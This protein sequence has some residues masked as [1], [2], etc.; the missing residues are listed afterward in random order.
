[1]KRIAISIAF[2]LFLAPFIAGNAVA[3]VDLDQTTDVK[4]GLLSPQTGELSA[5]TGGFERAAELAVD[6][7]NDDADFADYTFT[8]TVY[9]TQTSPTGA[10]AAMTQAVTDGMH[11]VVG[12][13]GSS[14]TLAAAAVAV[15]NEVPLISYASTS[16]DLTTF[17]DNGYLWRTPP[18]DALQGKVIADVADEGGYTE[19][20]IIALDNAYGAGL[21]ASV[22]SNFE[23]GDGT[24]LK[25]IS[26]AAETTDFANIVDQVEAESP[27]I[28]VAISY[29]TDGS[30]LFVEMDTQELD[31][32]VIGADGIADEQI[33]AATTGT[34]EAMEGFVTTKPTA[35]SSEAGTAFVAAYEAAYPDATGDIYT[36]ETY[37][38]VLAGAIAI[39]DAA[40]TAGAD[41]IASLA[42][43]TFDGATGPLQFDENGDSSAGFYEIGNVQD[44]AIVAVGSWEPVGGLDI[45]DDDFASSWGSSSGGGVLPFP[46]FGFFVAIAF[47]AVIVR[48]RK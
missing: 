7:L 33:F 37:D 39:K 4:V 40:S 26:Y 22:K 15:S 1:M 2:L 21:A 12:A 14:N 18:S 23:A 36:G 29:A 9:D 32:A 44:G 3:G 48:R 41:I 19:M 31:V 27:D 20:V 25:T 24:V 42:T 17:E 30:L 43:I 16:P 46:F 8:L 6:H 10:S 13:A 35:V 38:A 5:Y 47:S 28:V 11:Y 45:T 34:A